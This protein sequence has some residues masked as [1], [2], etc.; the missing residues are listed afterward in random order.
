M[1]VSFSVIHDTEMVSPGMKT[2][3][4]RHGSEPQYFLN[5]PSSAAA[6]TPS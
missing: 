6:M 2:V 5:S 4:D 1:V 3:L